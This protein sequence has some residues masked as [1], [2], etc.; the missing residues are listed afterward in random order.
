[1]LFFLSFLS[2]F[3]SCSQEFPLC[4]S[5]FS[6]LE[7]TGTLH[8]PAPLPA[9]LSPHATC[10]MPNYRH[11]GKQCGCTQLLSPPSIPLSQPPLSQN[12][13]KSSDRKAGQLHKTLHCSGKAG[14][15]SPFVPF[16]L[17]STLVCCSFNTLYVFKFLISKNQNT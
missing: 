6:A 11:A 17:M 2:V 7:A 8:P 10:H 16:S 4:F 1:M 9:S 15:N 13:T 14:E 5:V 12:L 3:K